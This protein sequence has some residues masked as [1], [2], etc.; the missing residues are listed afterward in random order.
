MPSS[1]APEPQAEMEFVPHERNLRVHGL[2]LA[3]KVW[4]IRATGPVRHHVLALHGWL[5]NA[6]SF[7][8]LAPALL[9]AGLDAEIVA[10]DLAGHGLSQHRPEAASYEFIDWVPDIV[11]AVDALEWERLTLLGHS[12]GGAI[13]T[14]AAV[15]MP[16][17]IENL[18][19]L[20]VLGPLTTL[21]EDAP[22]A[23]VEAIRERR[24]R[25]PR[26]SQSY[27]SIDAAVERLLRIN[28]ALDE[29]SARLLVARGLRPTENGFVWR[30][31]LRLRQRSLLTMGEARTQAVLGAI[32]CP[33]LIVRAK[34]GW[35]LPDEILQQRLACVPRA[36]W[37]EVEG[38]HHVH[39]VHPERVVPH[40][41]TFFG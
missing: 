6:A 9:R 14:F 28:P 31:D 32:G 22:Q 8:R 30:H 1:H 29:P 34:D 19:L 40:L 41:L 35:P 37:I 4:R 17:E 21:A 25:L 5:D 16:A 12:L 15:A 11:A 13:A 23:L 18:V 38:R 36:R 26:R 2:Q 24:H 7:D 39:L 27:A 33:T 20:D 3:T 10:L